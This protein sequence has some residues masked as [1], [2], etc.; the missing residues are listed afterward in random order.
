VWNFGAPADKSLRTA[1]QCAS[2]ILTGHYGYAPRV[3]HMVEQSQQY[4]PGGGGAMVPTTADRHG[5]AIKVGPFPQEASPP[6][7]LIADAQPNLFGV[8][9]AMRNLRSHINTE[10]VSK[11]VK[12]ATT[13]QSSCQ[14]RL[15][16]PAHC[17]CFRL[18]VTLHLLG[19]KPIFPR[20]SP[21]EPYT[22]A[23]SSIVRGFCKVGPLVVRQ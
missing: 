5:F 3:P 23:L 19:R 17:S 6:S 1:L 15:V 14:S 18:M 9:M 16:R 2:Y 12:K 4:Y 21:H 11:M 10:H 20:L 13:S 22:L 7:P 8:G